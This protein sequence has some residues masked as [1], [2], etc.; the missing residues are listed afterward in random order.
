MKDN[1]QI[2]LESIYSDILEAYWDSRKEP[3][4]EPSQ[5]GYFDADKLLGKRVWVHTNRSNR[6]AGRNGMLGVYIPAIKG[7]RET[8]SDQRYGYTNEIRL[9]DIV[10]D[11]NIN[12]LKNIKET[13]KRTLCAGII[14][15][16]IKTDGN[17]SGFEEFTL[18]PFGEV[19]GYYRK[20]DSEKRMITGADEV[21][22]NATEDGKYIVVARGIK[23]ENNT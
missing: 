12:C 7:N 13:E 4:N 11:V 9:A 15:T 8:R 14:G 18:D 23:T 5:L 10:F 1:D 3:A 22:M 17:L 20:N 6:N 19:T 21:Y 2:F 16:V